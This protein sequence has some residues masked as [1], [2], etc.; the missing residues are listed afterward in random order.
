MPVKVECDGCHGIK[1]AAIQ[2][3]LHRI[4]TCEAAGELL[5]PLAE[6][7][8]R[9]LDRLRAVPQDLGE[10]YELVYAFIRGGGKLPVMAR[11][12]EGNGTLR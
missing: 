10:A 11:W 2:D 3:A 12:I 8:G 4:E 1:E 7:L 5:D 6:R 9:A